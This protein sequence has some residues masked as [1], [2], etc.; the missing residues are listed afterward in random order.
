M[1]MAVGSGEREKLMAKS[2]RVTVKGAR[3]KK[4][5]QKGNYHV[6]IIGK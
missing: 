6:T 3:T 5:A 4:I 2:S 1:P